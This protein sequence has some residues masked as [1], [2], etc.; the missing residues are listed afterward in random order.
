[1]QRLPDIDC[2]KTQ[3][4]DYQ[5]HQIRTIVF[6]LIGATLLGL[7][8]SVAYAVPMMTNYQGTLQ[9][10]SG[11]PLNT[12]VSMTFSLYDTPEGGTP[13]WT[14]THPDVTVTNGVFSVVLGS[15]INFTAADV[16]GERYLG[17]T[18]GTDEEMLPRQ[19]LV[20]TSS[21]IRAG[22][23]EFVTDLSGHSAT[24]LNDLNSVGSGAII[25]AEEREKLGSLTGNVPPGHL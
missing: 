20:S 11:S 16:E 25:T 3:W 4:R 17:V 21:S 12:S 14:E 2:S 6:N 10:T 15:V 19:A 1:M 7:I 23:A 22:V 8:S 18:V 13:L 5:K 24:E 9:D